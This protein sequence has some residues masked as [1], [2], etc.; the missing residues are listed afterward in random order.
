M[1]GAPAPY[2]R[3]L[4]ANACACK[5]RTCI[6]PG[7]KNKCVFPTTISF[8]SAI[9]FS[10]TS[11]AIL[12]IFLSAV[13]SSTLTSSSS[14]RR[15]FSSS[16]SVSLMAHSSSIVNIERLTNVAHPS[17]VWPLFP[18]HD[19]ALYPRALSTG[20]YKSSNHFLSTSCSATMS[21]SA[22]RTSSST[23]CNLDSA[24]ARSGAKYGY[25]VDHVCEYASA[26][27]LYVITRTSARDVDGFKRSNASFRGGSMLRTRWLSANRRG[28]PPLGRAST[29]NFAPMTSEVGVYMRLVHT[30]RSV[31][32]SSSMTDQTYATSS[33]R[34]QNVAP[35]TDAGSGCPHT[36]QSTVVT[37]AISGAS[38]LTRNHSSPTARA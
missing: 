12:V 5:M 26:N 1:S 21:A 35:T 4:R 29:T 10:F 28:S 32:S 23:F 13:L 38:S 19:V 24:R 20:S 7:W 15:I 17:C 9:D 34:R 3:A 22:T 36:G 27:T 25:I 8:P 2:S 33:S 30:T 11:C 14:H 18:H 16:S 37:P 6:A 31:P